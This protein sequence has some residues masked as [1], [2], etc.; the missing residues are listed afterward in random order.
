MTTRSR[1]LLALALAAGAGLALTAAPASAGGPSLDRAK[2]TARGLGPVKIGMTVRQARAATSTTLR[3]TQRNGTCAVLEQAGLHD[4]VYFLVLNGR[5]RRATIEATNSVNFTNQ[6]ARG[7]K[8]AQPESRMRRL[9]GRPD[10]TRRD[11]NSGGFRFI[12][13]ADLAG[14]P[15]R[16]FV[17]ET[18]RLSTSI[19][20][21]FVNTM[22]VGDTPAVL[23]YEACS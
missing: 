21:R 23:F 19:R 9:Y 1:S 15:R 14:S 4:G 17:F 6:T 2:L 11:V 20:G 16:R 22:S 13:N 10:A 18:A 12:Y 7:L 8:L 3:I 5:I